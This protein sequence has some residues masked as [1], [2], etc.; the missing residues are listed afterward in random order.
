MQDYP[1]LTFKLGFRQSLWGAAK[2][3]IGDDVR[4]YGTSENRRQKSRRE[5]IPFV[6]RQGGPAGIG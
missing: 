2:S 5:R 3:R 6:E 1:N 4:K